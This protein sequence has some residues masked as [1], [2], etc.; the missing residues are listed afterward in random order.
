[1]RQDLLDT[2][3]MMIGRPTLWPDGERYSFHILHRAMMFRYAEIGNAIDNWC[4]DHL[5][6]NYKL[7][8][9]FNQGDPYYSLQCSKE[10]AAVFVL[11]FGGAIR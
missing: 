8:Q 4:R 2:K 11:H 5:S 7:L 6:G 3:D 9:D 1:M 10:D